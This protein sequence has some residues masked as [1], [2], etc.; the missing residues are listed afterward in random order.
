MVEETLYV[1]GTEL[2]AL[3]SLAR[4]QKCGKVSVMVCEGQ[5]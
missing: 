2:D 3:L 1:S 5:T 4:W